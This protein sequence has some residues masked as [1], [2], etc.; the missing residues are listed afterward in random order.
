MHAV[1]LQE[2]SSELSLG[3]GWLTRIVMRI[4][5]VQIIDKIKD[6]IDEGEQFFSFEFFPPK[7]EE[8]SRYRYVFGKNNGQESLP[9]SLP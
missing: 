1:R 6:A 3:C 8:V 9:D 4:R 2:L 7:T 5:T